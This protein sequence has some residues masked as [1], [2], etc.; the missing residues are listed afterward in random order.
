MRRRELLYNCLH[1]ITSEQ[2]HARYAICTLFDI[3]L[4]LS[5]IRIRMSHCIAFICRP[6]LIDQRVFITPGNKRNSFTC[7]H[8]RFDWWA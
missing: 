4:L 7:K 2:R 8:L 6:I 5:V 1:A 3:V